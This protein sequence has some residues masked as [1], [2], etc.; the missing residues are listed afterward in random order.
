MIRGKICRDVP[1]LLCAENRIERE[2]RRL[3]MEVEHQRKFY[4]FTPHIVPTMFISGGAGCA[5][6]ARGHFRSRAN[7][8]LRFS[9]NKMRSRS[10]FPPI[11]I[12]AGNK[13]KIIRRHE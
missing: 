8:K 10:R 6:A 9:K 4:R 12:R 11:P 3:V 7:L 2:G 1:A 13:A 5:W